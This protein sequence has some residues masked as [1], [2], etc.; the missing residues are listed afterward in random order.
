MKETEQWGR[1]EEREEVEGKTGK[2]N[3]IGK[4]KIR[5]GEKIKKRYR[6]RRAD[7]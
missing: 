4:K 2:K 1:C 7:I 6:K 3:Q 5:G